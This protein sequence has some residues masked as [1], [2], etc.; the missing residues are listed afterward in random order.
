M[1]HIAPVFAV[2]FAAPVFAAGPE[3]EM[4]VARQALRDGLWE[5]ARTHALAAGG[6][7][8]RLAFLESYARE[9]RWAEVLRSLEKFGDPA[10]EGFVCYRAAA[11]AKTGDNE[12]ARRCLGQV[13]FSQPEFSA[14]AALVLAGVDLAENRPRDAVARLS[15]SGAKGHEARMLMAEAHSRLGDAKAARAIWREVAVSTNAP[16]RVRVPAAAKLGDVSVLRTVYAAAGDP[17]LR[18]VAGMSLGVALIGTDEGFAEGGK[19]VRSLARDAPDTEGAKGAMLALG[20]AYRRRGD[21]AGAIEVYGIASETWPDL[22]TSPELHYGRGAALLK[23]GRAEE[24]LKDL[25][26]AAELFSGG[27][28]GAAALVM[29]ADALAALGRKDEAMARYR[30]VLAGHPGTESA[31]RVAEIVKV[32]ELEDKGRALYAEYRFAEAQQTFAEVA[33]ADPSRAGA[34][35]YCAVLCLY[36]QGRDDEAAAMAKS[37]A[38]GEGP[39]DVRAAAKLWLAKLAF[40]SARWKE[41]VA[42][43]SAYVDILPESA[44]APGSLVWAARAAFAGNDYPLAV[45]T[46]KRLSEKYPRSKERAAGLLVQGEALI[47]L[48]R[49]DEAVLVLELA[50]M[51]SEAQSRE[52]FRAQLL[53]ADASFA[54]GADNPA[55]YA[56]A[57]DTYRALLLG[58]HL[59]PSERISLSYKIGK[60]LEKTGRADE[61]A[62]QYYTQVVLAYR[63]GRAR[64]LQYDDGA[65]A[66]FS[67]AAFSLAEEFESRGRD[68]QAERI[69]ALVVASGVPAADEAGRRI[70]RIR[71]K[72][73]LL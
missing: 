39:A 47:E 25:E 20:D 24:A 41:A 8:G 37:I 12:A 4:A 67:R 18:R 23:T 68:D 34:M 53:K 35:S 59:S 66:D 40:N 11:L 28:S 56:A 31:K 33:K 55:R 36:G 1:K 51:A 19:L 58:E 14:A 21:W 50:A 17:R 73:N 7:E 2:L 6:D 62:D 38:D 27:E 49:F 69:L 48:A 42:L 63:D 64:G 10:G 52:R 29:S 60:V 72:G 65:R 5:I 57:L 43:F 44:A 13:T 16:D 32:R 3:E 54:M 45:S 9:G 30:E 15:D 71:R 46:V 26:R 61:A 70:E 22:A